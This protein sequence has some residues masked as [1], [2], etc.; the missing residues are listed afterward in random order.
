MV[1]Q[2]RSKVDTVHQLSRAWQ[3]ADPASAASLAT[4]DG[5]AISQQLADAALNVTTLGLTDVSLTPVDGSTDL[6]RLTWRLSG[7]DHAASVMLALRWGEGSQGAAIA[8]VMSGGTTTPLWVLEDLTASVSPGVLVSGGASDAV[9]ALAPDATQA[10]DRVRAFFAEWESDLIV[11]APST[12]DLFAETLAAPPGEY[13]E[14]AALTTSTDGTVGPL[15]GLRVLVHPV[16]YPAMTTG[17]ARLVLTHEATHVATRSVTSELPLWWSE[18][19]AE[20]VAFS[21]VPAQDRRLAE[22]LLEQAHDALT[23][24]FAQNG[25]PDRLPVPA[26]FAGNR[27]DAFYEASRRAVDTLVALAGPADVDESAE[28]LWEFNTR[29]ASGEDVEVALTECFGVTY[30]DFIRAWQGALTRGPSPP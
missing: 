7:A 14:V 21:T 12:S 1:P 6:A 11:E 23:A 18:G 9:Q 29:L 22:D 28:Q 13:D 3:T 27:Q 30:P 2:A 25:V 20:H 5:S 8:G 16:N 15:A 26:D 10:R 24:E 4:P 19:L 17:A